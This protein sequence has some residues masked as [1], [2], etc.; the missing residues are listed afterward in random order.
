MCVLS[1]VA[2][3]MTGFSFFFFVKP[4]LENHNFRLIKTKKVVDILG[5]FSLQLLNIWLVHGGI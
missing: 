4:I 1:D 3:Q 2:M 5:D